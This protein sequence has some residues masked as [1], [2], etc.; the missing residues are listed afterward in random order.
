MGSDSQSVSKY[1]VGEN[2]SAIENHERRITR[3][4]KAMWVGIGAIASISLVLG[5]WG[6]IEFALKAF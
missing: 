4:E 2:E 6:F 3:L 1:R 5:S